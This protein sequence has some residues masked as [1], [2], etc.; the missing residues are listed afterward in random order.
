[1]K[2]RF[3]VIG[4]PVPKPAP[5][6]RVVRG[7]PHVYIPA[8]KRHSVQEW[9]DKIREAFEAAKPDGWHIGHDDGVSIHATF[10]IPPNKTG[11][12][13]VMPLSKDT[14]DL[15]NYEKGLLDAL[16]TVAFPDDAQ[17]VDKHT[18]KAY[19]FS[20]NPGV[21]ITISKVEQPIWP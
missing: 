8:A 19:A 2:I 15:D 4:K 18:K 20:V 21:S 14:G 3:F 11:R 9:Q 10:F 17:V 5:Q 7:K 16:K 1:M 12:Q 6:F 13:R